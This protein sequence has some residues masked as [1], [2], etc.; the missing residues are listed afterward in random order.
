[1]DEDDENYNKKIAVIH[2]ICNLPLYHTK[3]HVVV[4]KEPKLAKEHIEDLY[5]GIIMNFSNTTLS[6]TCT[7]RHDEI[8]DALLVYI[9]ISGQDPEQPIESIVAH[10]AVNLGWVLTDELNVKVDSENYVTQAY[11]VSDIVKN[12]T[13]VIQQFEEENTGMGDL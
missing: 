6:Y 12:I 13:K 2:Q 9:K 7:I 4:S 8:G 5:P 3:Y 11:I 1:M 10:E